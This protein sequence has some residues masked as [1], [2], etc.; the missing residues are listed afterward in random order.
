MPTWELS[1]TTTLMSQALNVP[2][3]GI[4]GVPIISIASKIGYS[5][6]LTSVLLAAT[7]LAVIASHANAP[8]AADHATRTLEVIVEY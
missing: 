6:S 5:V 1:I 2:D 8:A 4:D 3:R 7:A